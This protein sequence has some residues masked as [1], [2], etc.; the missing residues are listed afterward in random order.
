MIFGAGLL[1]LVLL[2]VGLTAWRVRQHRRTVAKLD[3]ALRER[4]APRADSDRAD[5]Q[6]QTEDLEGS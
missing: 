5:A 6:T 3:H 1:A 2:A 4:M